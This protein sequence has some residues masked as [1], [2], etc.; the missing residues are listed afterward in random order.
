MSENLDLV[1]SISADWERGDFSRT[2]W[3]APEIESEH[4]DG[5]M[6]GRWQGLAGVARAWREWVC[7]W[8]DL[9]ATADDFRQLDGGRVLVRTSVSGRNKTTGLQ[10]ASAA[11]ACL[12][13][14]G[15]GKVTRLVVYWDRD[16]ALA[17]LGLEA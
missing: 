8:E 6:T 11:G 12:F 7:A 10:F 4:P 16:H 1:R 17:D 2:D 9:R 15:D 3:A 14:I 13:T 5:V